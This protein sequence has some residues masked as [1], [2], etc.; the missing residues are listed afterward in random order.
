MPVGR[1]NGKVMLRL[2]R[3]GSGEGEIGR[4]HRKE[5]GVE[6][7]GGQNGG[8]DREE[9]KVRGRRRGKWRGR[10]LTDMIALVDICYRFD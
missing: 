6:G 7:E 10:D 3:A 2:A 5:V 9:E 8:G 4:V 1:S